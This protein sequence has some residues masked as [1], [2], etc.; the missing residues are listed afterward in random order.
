MAE[1]YQHLW[2]HQA[3]ERPPVTRTGGALP[4]SDDTRDDEHEHYA[5]DLKRTY[6][7][8][9]RPAEIVRYPRNVAFIGSPA[10]LAVGAVAL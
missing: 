3:F 8:Y 2:T 1:R 7:G 4:P 5:R 10:A 9:L 6:I